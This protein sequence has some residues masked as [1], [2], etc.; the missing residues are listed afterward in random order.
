MDIDKYADVCAAHSIEHL[1]GHRLSEERVISL[2]DKNALS[3]PLYDHTSLC[4]PSKAK[5]SQSV[6]HKQI[7]EE[8]PMKHV[9]K[10]I[11]GYNCHNRK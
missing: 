6:T 4:P 2:G 5:K 3:R 10:G 8:R 11:Q 1:A 9:Q 7:Y